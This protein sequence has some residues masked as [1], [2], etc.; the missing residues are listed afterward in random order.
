[1]L[2]STHPSVIFQKLEDGAVLFAP[3]S[4]LY[5]GLN[6]VGAMIWMLLPE[7]RSIGDLCNAVAA[8]YPEVA[9]SVIRTDIEELLQ[10]LVREGLAV[11]STSGGG[12]AVQAS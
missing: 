6:E 11:A 4:E 8:R 5:F 2:P 7:V 10:Q 9:P 12:D 1:M 3:G